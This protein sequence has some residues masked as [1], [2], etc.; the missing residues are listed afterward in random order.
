MR[1][2]DPERPLARRWS[3]PTIDGLQLLTEILGA[4]VQRCRRENALR[5]NVDD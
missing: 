4:G 5:S 3:Q 1:A 2:R